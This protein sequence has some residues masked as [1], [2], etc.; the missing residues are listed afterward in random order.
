MSTTP[1]NNRPRRRSAKERPTPPAPAPA[2][3]ARLAEIFSST[4]GPSWD[5]EADPAQRRTKH[6]YQ[7]LLIWRDLLL[8][9]VEQEGD[10]ESRDLVEVLKEPLAILKTRLTSTPAYSRRWLLHSIDHG[11]T[12]VSEFVCET[13]LTRAEVE[14]LLEELV[15]EGL[16]DKS[17]DGRSQQ[18]RT[19]ADPDDLSNF[20]F[21]RKG[22][23]GGDAY[24]APAPA[25]CSL[26]D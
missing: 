17:P 16:V 11:A 2:A 9:Q 8:Q 3:A 7:Q 4:P 23:P 13:R 1:V 5:V 18:G 21:T 12:T 10:E 22:A 14:R 15:A 24:S 26:P 19:T 6:V 25:R 20:L